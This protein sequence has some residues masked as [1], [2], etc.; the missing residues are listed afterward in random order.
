[1][2]SKKASSP[3]SHT[4]GRQTETIAAEQLIPRLHCIMAVGGVQAARHRSYTERLFMYE[5]AKQEFNIIKRADCTYIAFIHAV[6][7]ALRI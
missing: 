2:T 5:Y 1:M 7:E 4:G 3:V 6:V